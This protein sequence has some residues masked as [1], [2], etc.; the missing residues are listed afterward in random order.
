MTDFVDSP[1]GVGSAVARSMTVMGY[2]PEEVERIR[3][4]NATAGDL[5]E[6]I[7]RIIADFDALS[8]RR[9]TA[10]NPRYLVDRLR[11]A[12]QTL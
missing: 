3:K 11:D 8:S 4:L 5:R 1:V 7:E 12:I 10:V 9:K 2:P 6:R